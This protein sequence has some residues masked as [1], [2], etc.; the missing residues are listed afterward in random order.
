MI[1]AHWVQGDKGTVKR[2]I[3]ESRRIVKADGYYAVSLDCFQQWIR[4]GTKTFSMKLNKIISLFNKGNE[5]PGDN[6]QQEIGVLQRAECTSKTRERGHASIGTLTLTGRQTRALTLNRKTQNPLTN[7]QMEN[8][9]AGM[10]PILH[11]EEKFHQNVSGSCCKPIYIAGT[12]L[13]QG[14]SLA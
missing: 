13:P 14:K 12:K 5:L 10:P 3:K 6:L 4:G 8:T 2:C 1:A 11:Q 9:R 7:Y